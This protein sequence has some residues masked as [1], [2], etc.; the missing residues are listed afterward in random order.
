MDA[1]KNNNGKPFYP[2][3]VLGGGGFAKE[4]KSALNKGRPNYDH[5]HFWVHLAGPHFSFL[6]YP[7]MQHQMPLL[8]ERTRRIGANLEKSDLVNFQGPN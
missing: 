2:V 7:R 4:G 5:D 1:K 3:L 6:G 8:S